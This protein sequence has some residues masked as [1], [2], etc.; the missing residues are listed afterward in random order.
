MALQRRE[1]LMSASLGAPGVAGLG[2]GARAAEKASCPPEGE[3]LLPVR[4]LGLES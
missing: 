3:D 4:R 1:W 2:G